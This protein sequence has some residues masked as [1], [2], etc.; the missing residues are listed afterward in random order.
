[1]LKIF[2]EVIMHHEPDIR[3]VNPHPKCN[4]RNNNPNLI[5]EKPVLGLMSDRLWQIGMVGKG[6]EPVFLQYSG[7]ISNLPF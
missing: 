4:R 7:K 6:G 2:R 5:P 1:M 3:L